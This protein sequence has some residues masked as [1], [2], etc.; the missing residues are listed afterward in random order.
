MARLAAH[1]VLDLEALAAQR[2]RRIVRM[3]I[4]AELRLV[5]RLLD[6]EVPRDLLRAIVEEDLVGPASRACRRG[7]HVTYSFCRTG[8]SLHFVIEPWQ[9]LFAHSPRPGASR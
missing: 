8:E 5:R 7:T 1:A 9:R 3:A 6:A 2:R 4:D